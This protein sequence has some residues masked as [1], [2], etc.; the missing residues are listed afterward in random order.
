M[1]FMSMLIKGRINMKRDYNRVEAIVLTEHYGWYEVNCEMHPIRI[2]FDEICTFI[3]YDDKGRLIFEECN[4]VINIW[5]YDESNNIV[6]CKNSDGYEYWEM[7]D[8]EN[9]KICY[10]DTDG[11]IHHTIY[12]NSG[13]VTV[14][15]NEEIDDYYELKFYDI[16]NNLVIYRTPHY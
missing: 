8:D 1:V 2:H 3:K 15:R 12:L 13:W 9:R 6:Y 11:F 14:E 7:Y 4:E 10:Q 16:N 5:E